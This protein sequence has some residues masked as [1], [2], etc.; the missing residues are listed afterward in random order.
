MSTYSKLRASL[1]GIVGETT[2]FPFKELLEGPGCPDCHVGCLIC[3]GL[4]NKL[5]L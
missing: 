4:L 1:L 2:R 3:F 5:M